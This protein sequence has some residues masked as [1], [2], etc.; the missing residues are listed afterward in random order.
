MEKEDFIQT[1]KNKKVDFINNNLSA[2]V[3]F[4]EIYDAAMHNN[5][6]SKSRETLANQ[7][8]K[9][10]Y[11]INRE[12]QNPENMSAPA[13]TSES[14]DKNQSQIKSDSDEQL[15]KILH[16]SDD[17]MQMLE[18]WK[19]NQ[20]KSKLIDDRLNLQ[21]PD[22]GEEL[23]KTLRINSQ[24]WNEWKAFCGKHPVFSEKELLAKALWSYINTETH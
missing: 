2:G 1:D 11:L 24:I 20:A 16:S 6:F 23:R 13:T 14:P 21:F 9:A 15:G 10:G 22:S 8:K 19:N 4:K 17:L 7:F 12:P 18:W 5:E 3:S